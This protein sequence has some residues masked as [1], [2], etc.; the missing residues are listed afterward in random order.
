MNDQQKPKRIVDH[1]PLKKYVFCIEDEIEADQD[2]F[3]PTGFNEYIR[4]DDVEELLQENAQL[5]N[6]I[7]MLKLTHTDKKPTLW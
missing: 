4:I 6:E 3:L 5:K 2:D 7:L 1:L